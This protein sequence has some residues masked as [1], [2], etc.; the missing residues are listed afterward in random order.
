MVF[1]GKDKAFI[2]NLGYEL[3]RL[4]TVPEKDGKVKLLT[5][6]HKEDV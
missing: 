6:L 3:R 1:T 5:K 4:I 2:K